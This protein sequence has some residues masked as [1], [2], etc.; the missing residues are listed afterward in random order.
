VNTYNTAT[1]FTEVISPRHI[2]P[3][4]SSEY[5]QHS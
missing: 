5:L 3:R 1:V 2:S 4:H